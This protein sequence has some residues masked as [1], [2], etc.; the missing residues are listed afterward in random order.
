MIHHGDEEVQQ[1]DDIDDGIR[2]KHQHT[3][4]SCEYFDTVQL[5]TLEVN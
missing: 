1:Y 3:P 4:K 5:E 2:S